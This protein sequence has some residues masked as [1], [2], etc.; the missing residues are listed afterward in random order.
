MKNNKAFLHWLEKTLI[1]LSKIAVVIILLCFLG[2]FTYKI[3][4]RTDLERYS[5]FVMSA[6]EVI[7]ITTYEESGRASAFLTMSEKELREY[8]LKTPV[9]KVNLKLEHREK[10]KEIL[11]FDS[12][13]I[14]A[15]PVCFDP[16]H[17]VIAKK[18]SEIMLY[19]I[20]YTCSMVIIKHGQYEYSGTA[21]APNEPLIDE[22]FQSSYF[23]KQA[24]GRPKS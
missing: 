8:D 2:Y 10:L 4:R 19:D 11:E 12:Q 20:C 1:K 17:F 18:G 9:R 23:A 7:L 3:V 14:N 16:H 5:N 6:D 15:S 21:S 24:K 13:R 22:V